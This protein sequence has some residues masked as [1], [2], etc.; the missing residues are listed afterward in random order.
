MRA[1][2]GREQRLL[3]AKLNGLV[4]SENHGLPGMRLHFVALK[5]AALGVSLQIQFACFAPNTVVIKLL[6]AAEAHL[7]GAHETKNVRGERVVRII[8][9]RLLTR[10]NSVQL[11]SIQFGGSLLV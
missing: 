6:D 10:V 1:L 2:D 8:T 7:I 11:Q 9:L 5:R 4:D 3:G